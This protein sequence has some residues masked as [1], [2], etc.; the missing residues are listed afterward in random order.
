MTMGVDPA[1][2]KGGLKADGD[3]IGVS[4]MIMRVG[5]TCEKNLFIGGLIMAFLMGTVSPA[6]SFVFGGMI[7]SVGD[8][9]DLSAEEAREMLQEKADAAEAQAW[10]NMKA[11]ALRMAFVGLY[12]WVTYGLM[13]FGM[14][15]AAN[16]AAYKIRILYF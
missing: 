9:P 14:N 8:F 5:S 11:S 10:D 2:G 15:Y 13:V 12:A 3:P 16:K 7:D 6:F 1:G 4:E